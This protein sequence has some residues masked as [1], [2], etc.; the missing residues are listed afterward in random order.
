MTVDCSMRRGRL[1]G[2][3]AL[4]VFFALIQGCAYVHPIPNAPLNQ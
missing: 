3:F 2:L 4:L 1:F